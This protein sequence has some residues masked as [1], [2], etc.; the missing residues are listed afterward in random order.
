MYLKGSFKKEWIYSFNNY[1]K[2]LREKAMDILGNKSSLC[3]TRSCIS[4]SN[5]V[6]K[7]NLSTYDYQTVLVAGE[8][9]DTVESR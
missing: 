3:K 8:G 5:G 9:G 6:E 4:H 1:S 2:D 7:E